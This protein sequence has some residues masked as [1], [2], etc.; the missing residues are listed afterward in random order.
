[1]QDAGSFQANQV[2]YRTLNLPSAGAIGASAAVFMATVMIGK[3]YMDHY[4]SHREL[5]S[6]MSSQEEAIREVKQEVKEVRQ[7]MNARIDKVEESNKRQ[8][9][10]NKVLFGV[11]LV[12]I[13]FKPQGN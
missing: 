10:G 4:S 7:E 3:G 9:A 6:R 1:M 12:A 13:F 11:V 8:D 2:A 5:T